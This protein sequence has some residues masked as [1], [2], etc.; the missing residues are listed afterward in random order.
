MAQTEDLPDLKARD[1]AMATV[2]IQKAF[3][4]HQA[5]QK[6]KNT[7][8]ASDEDLPDLKCADVAA[9]TVKIQK[10]YRGNSFIKNDKNSIIIIYS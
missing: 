6:V 2:K 8:K 10:V 3:R 7:I 1:V 4:G 9:A 5:R